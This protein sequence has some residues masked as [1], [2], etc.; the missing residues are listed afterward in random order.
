MDPTSTP[1]ITQPVTIPVENSA[2]LS[3]TPLNKVWTKN[4]PIINLIFMIISVLL[5]FGLDLMILISSFNLLPFWIE[6][7]KVFGIFILFFCFENFV[8]RKRFANTKSSLDSWVVLFIV[9]RNLFCLIGFIPFIQL[10]EMAF[11]IYVLVPYLIIYA[12]LIYKRF[13]AV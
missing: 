10:I 13:K 6:M 4:V 9:I 3:S 1:T 7:L 12:I 8:C 11:G 5:V 2:I